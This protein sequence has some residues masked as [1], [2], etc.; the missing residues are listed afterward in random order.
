MTKLNLKKKLNLLLE[1]M[2]VIVF[3]CVE[4]QLINGKFFKLT[5][6][7]NKYLLKDKQ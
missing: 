3:L 5:S 2:Q 1:G 7:Q 4:S 6:T